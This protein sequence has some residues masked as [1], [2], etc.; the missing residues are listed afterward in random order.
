MMVNDTYQAANGQLVLTLETRDGIVLSKAKLPY[1][2]PE[3]GDRTFQVP[4]LIP[5]QLGDC[6]LKAA[7]IPD[8]KAPDGPTLSRRWVE[9]GR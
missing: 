9:V 4:L 2:V 6:I 5:N 7:A 3:L 1:A 8:G